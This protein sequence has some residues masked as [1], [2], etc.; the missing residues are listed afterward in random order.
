MTG[1]G[2][3]WTFCHLLMRVTQRPDGTPGRP[4]DP[5]QG[6]YGI[7]I[8]LATIAGAIAAILPARAASR[9]DPVEVIQQ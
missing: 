8:T 9:V 3:G 5:T 4:V 7:A 1:A 6:E 2:L